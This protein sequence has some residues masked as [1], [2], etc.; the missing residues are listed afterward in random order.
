MLKSKDII[1]DI[2][3]DI[4]S[5]KLETD[6]RIP[7]ESQLAI[8]YDCNRHTIRKVTESLIERGYLRKIHGG[9]TF[10][11]PLPSNHSLNL[12]SLFELHGENNITSK[13][14]K[15]RLKVASQEV[16]NILKLELGSKVWHIVRI[17]YVANTPSHMEETYIPYSLFPDL[18]KEDCLHS[19][20]HYVENTLDYEVSHA[21]KN[22][23]AIKL[24]KKECEYLELPEESLAI[25]IDNTGYLTNG[26]A[27]EYSVNKHRD[28]NIV[29]YAKR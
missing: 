26:R 22:I 11:N 5:G 25:Q 7:S 23:S 1:R 10:V 4:T 17:R 27:Y 19:L 8:K 18:K 20:L 24:S 15:F 16:C 9:P 29:Y 21:I 6:S 14:V 28:N 2:I 3:E 13:V 12:S